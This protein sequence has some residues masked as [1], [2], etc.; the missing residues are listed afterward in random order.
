MPK[1][2]AL[3]EHLNKLLTHIKAYVRKK[4]YHP[5]RLFIILAIHRAHGRHVGVRTFSDLRFRSQ[6]GSM[7]YPLYMKSS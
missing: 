3:N 2:S 6:G 1:K 4:R 7:F 5:I